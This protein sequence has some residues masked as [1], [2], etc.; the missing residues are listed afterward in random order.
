MRGYFGALF[1]FAACFVGHSAAQTP[2]Y[3]KA[4]DNQMNFCWYDDELQ[5][6]GKQWRSDDGKDKLDVVTAFRCLKNA[7]I[8]IHAHT[9]HFKFYDSI[10]TNIEIMPVTHWD[11][12]Q[13]TAKA[14]GYE[15]EPCDRNTYV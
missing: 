9:H 1:L 12:E 10:V 14:E 7:R 3:S 2:P 8:C 4:C 15:W 5:A 13:I 6:F 11:N